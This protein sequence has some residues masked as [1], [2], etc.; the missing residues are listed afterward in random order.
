MVFRTD[1]RRLQ[2]RWLER[3]DRAAYHR[4]YGTDRLERDRRMRFLSLL[5]LLAAATVILCGPDADAQTAPANQSFSAPPGPPANPPSMPTAPPAAVTPPA[6]DDTT[7]EVAPRIIPIVPPPAEESGPAADEASDNSGATPLSL[8]HAAHGRPY[9]GVSVQPAL[10]RFHRQEICGLEIIGVDKG[11]PAERAG[12]TAPAGM[13]TVGATGETAG[14]FL[15]PVGLLMSPLLARSGQLGATGDMIVA[16][17]DQRVS[18]G[19][20]MNRALGRLAPGDIVWLTLMRITPDGKV[21]NEKVSIVL[22]SADSA[23]PPAAP[24]SVAPHH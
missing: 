2:A 13:T 20:E 5:V 9:L 16:V 7:L 8:S 10:V 21:K 3:R 24:P 6:E 19:A 15:G 11:S 4:E 14:F 17:D 12:L 1:P 22:G 23:A 18:V